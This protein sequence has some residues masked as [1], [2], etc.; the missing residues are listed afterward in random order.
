[1]KKI[2]LVFVLAMLCLGHAQQPSSKTVEVN[3]NIHFYGDRYIVKGLGDDYGKWFVLLESP[4]LE[5][6]SKDIDLFSPY[7]IKG[8]VYTFNNTNYLLP[9]NLEMQK[10][11]R[12]SKNIHKKK[13]A[14]KKSKSK[15]K[16]KKKS[17]RKKSGK[18]KSKKKSK[19]KKSRKSKAKKKRK[20]N[21]DEDLEDLE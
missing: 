16:T 5:K 14:K 7:R 15:K 3:G 19:R 10:K 12:S 4:L 21:D 11:L 20:S 18:K 13:K 2:I 8:K 6:I 17:K 9:T 1:M